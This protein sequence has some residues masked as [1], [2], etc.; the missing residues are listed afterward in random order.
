MFET[1][2]DL[3]L[4]AIEGGG[5]RQPVCLCGASVEGGEIE[6]LAHGPRPAQQL[7]VEGV[8]RLRFP[9]MVDDVRI[10]LAFHCLLDSSCNNYVGS[11]YLFCHLGWAWI[12]LTN[13]TSH[14]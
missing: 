11:G 2:H 3:D 5:E 4:L 7:E 10:L 12:K 8:Q 6:P 14:G 13:A 9:I 1:Y